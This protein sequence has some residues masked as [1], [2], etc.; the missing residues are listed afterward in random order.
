MRDDKARGERSQIGAGGGAVA[1]LVEMMACHLPFFA[2]ERP[3]VFVS[4]Q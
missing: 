4:L 1:I 3:S 2:R